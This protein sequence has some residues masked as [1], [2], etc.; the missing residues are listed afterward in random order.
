MG[1]LTMRKESESTRTIIYSQFNRVDSDTELAIVI[2]R[3]IPDSY[4]T[5]IIIYKDQIKM[6][7]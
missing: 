4:G 1:C 2:P 3:R 7:Q 5:N 6:F